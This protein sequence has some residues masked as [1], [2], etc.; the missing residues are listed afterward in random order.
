LLGAHRFQSLVMNVASIEFRNV[1]VVY[2]GTPGPAVDNLSMTVKAGE[3]VALVGASGSGKTS[4]LK[5]INRLHETASGEV[6]IDGVSV[7]DGDPVELRRRIGYVFQGIGLFPHMTIAENIVI[8]PRLLGWSDADR[9]ARVRELLD[10]VE[11]PQDFAERL[12]SQLSGGQQQRVGIAR[13]LA[14]RPKILLM[15]EP[16]GALDA[17]TRD[18]LGNACRNLHAALGLTTV[19]VTHDMQEAMLLSDRIVV[20]RAG[21]IAADGT[22]SE[23]ATAKA[24]EDVAALFEVP[25]RQAS[26]LARLLATGTRETQQ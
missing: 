23:I 25:R 12:P 5:T 9:L 7:R 22:P 18:N 8:T 13:A 24:D 6:F 4:L 15:D 16:F 2:D 20:M 1:A 14:A 11:L 17:V 3:F 19:M 21:K 26:N 10:L